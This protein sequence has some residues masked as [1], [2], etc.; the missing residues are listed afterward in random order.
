[1]DVM[2]SEVANASGIESVHYVLSNKF[3]MNDDDTVDINGN[4]MGPLKLNFDKAKC[5]IIFDLIGRLH[6]VDIS[7]EGKTLVVNTNG[8]YKNRLNWINKTDEWLYNKMSFRL[9]P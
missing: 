5:V 6:N 8:P 1:M 4:T 2:V 7:Y 9:F 3:R